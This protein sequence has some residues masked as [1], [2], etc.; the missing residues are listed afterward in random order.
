MMPGGDD[1]R[2]PVLQSFP[3]SGAP[4]AMP[5]ADGRNTVPLSAALQPRACWKYSNEDGERGDRDKADRE[6]GDVCERERA[7]LERTQRQQGVRAV[8]DRGLLRRAR[9]TTHA[10]SELASL[11]E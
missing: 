8:S 7:V 5:A 3:T 10:A 6:S 11:G 1:A 9:G 2:W 4:I